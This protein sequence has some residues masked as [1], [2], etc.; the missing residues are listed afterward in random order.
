MISYIK[1]AQPLA[2]N[3]I[4]KNAVGNL[5]CNAGASLEASALPGVSLH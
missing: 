5:A 2:A 1:A 4:I 3:N